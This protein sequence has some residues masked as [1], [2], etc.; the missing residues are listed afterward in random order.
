MMR[1]G[2]YDQFYKA[3]IDLEYA[4]PEYSVLGPDGGYKKSY[5]TSPEHHS[6]VLA[7]VKEQVNKYN[8]YTWEQRVEEATWES[9]FIEAVNVTD[10]KFNVILSEH[11]NIS[12]TFGF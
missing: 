9:T 3:D 10:K 5:Y 8:D 1:Q 4:L 7:F 11:Y 6:E 2:A 12:F